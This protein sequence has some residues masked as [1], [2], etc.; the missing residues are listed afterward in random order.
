MSVQLKKS[1]RLDSPEISA[2]I[3]R[4]KFWQHWIAAGQAFKA[5]RKSDPLFET[6]FVSKRFQ[7]L[8]RPLLWPLHGWLFTEGYGLWLDNKLVGHI[9][10][11]SKAR[12]ATHIEVLVVGEEYRSNIFAARLLRFAQQKALDKGHAYLTG[13]VTI[14]NNRVARLMQRK[15]QVFYYHFYETDKALPTLP[16]PPASQVRLEP[17]TG[18]TA[19]SNL[20]EFVIQENEVIDPTLIPLWKSVYPPTFAFTGKVQ[21]FA[22]YFDNLPTAEGHVCFKDLGGYKVW[23][24]YLNPKRWGTNSEQALIRL[25]LNRTPEFWRLQIRAGTNQH[26]QQLQQIMTDLNFSQGQDGR[27]TVVQKLFDPNLIK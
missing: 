10:L 24:L 27:I 14:S 6:E 18:K 5:L 12:M 21:N 20:T 23:W 26:H 15:S 3:K 7:F 22:V 17:L 13:W 25:M 16:M 4:L 11:Q 8:A 9:Y 2:P 1:E 19:K